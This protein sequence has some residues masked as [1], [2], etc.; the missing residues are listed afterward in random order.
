MVE[1][2]TPEMVEAMVESAGREG[3]HA[4]E[5]G[6]MVLADRHAR[7]H[8]R[9]P[10]PR[11]RRRGA[12][13]DPRLASRVRATSSSSATPCRRPATPATT[14][15]AVD[16]RPFFAPRERDD[17]PPG[18]P[19]AAQPVARAGLSVA[20]K[21]ARRRRPDGPHQRASATA[22]DISRRS[23][24]APTAAMV[25]LAA[26]SLDGARQAEEHAAVV[27]L[28][29]AARR[30]DG[31]G[32]RAAARAREGAG[33]A[34]PSRTRSNPAVLATQH[35]GTLASRALTRFT[36]H[37]RECPYSTSSPGP[38]RVGVGG[39]LPTFHPI[40]PKAESHHVERQR[41]ANPR[42]L[43][44]PPRARRRLRRGRP[45]RAARDVRNERIAVTSLKLTS[46]GDNYLLHP[47]SSRRAG[48]G[49]PAPPIRP[50]SSSACGPTTA[51][52]GARSARCRS[53][54]TAARTACSPRSRCSW[55]RRPATSW[56][57]A[58]TWRCSFRST[59]GT[60]LERPRL[61]GRGRQRLQE[62][63]SDDGRRRASATRTVVIATSATHC[64]TAPGMD[65]Q[66]RELNLSSSVVVVPV[67]PDG[68]AFAEAADRPD[69]NLS[70]SSRVVGLPPSQGLGS[71]RVQIHS[72][73]RP[74]G[75]NEA[76]RPLIQRKGGVSGERAP[77]RVPGHGDVTTGL[78]ALLRRRHPRGADRRRVVGRR[79]VRA[80]HLPRDRFQAGGLQR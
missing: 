12:G 39:V 46:A 25:E 71:G 40:A 10:Q 54:T 43:H 33:R 60:E 63:V 80:R 36:N 48:R 17:P 45:R 52:S 14:S 72:R 70:A 62:R 58:T 37:N 24:R 35:A 56:S 64:T 78:G 18:D 6:S 8:Q 49:R 11:G 27:L 38:A 4:V 68:D 22:A 67:D 15:C 79:R 19:R 23:E 7:R 3:L 55:C 74:L 26:D 34:G 32:R 59:R 1:R 13:G 50:T 57:A 30:G 69:F 5:R 44:P 16:I 29:E 28:G 47:V 21:N 41:Q 61:H 2:P 53:P 51:A 31:R 65:A 73:L 66:L 77:V 42:C 9:D 76:G 20:G 75:S